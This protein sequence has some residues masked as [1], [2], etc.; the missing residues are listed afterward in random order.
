LQA[1]ICAGRFGVDAK[2]EQGANVVGG[3]GGGTHGFGVA[4]HL[5]GLL[6]ISRCA[7]NSQLKSKSP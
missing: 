3:H 7:E 2:V 4:A 1:L 6:I 5:A